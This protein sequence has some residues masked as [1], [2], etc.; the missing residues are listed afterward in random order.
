MF[1]EHGFLDDIVRYLRG[2]AFASPLIFRFFTEDIISN[3]VYYG[4]TVACCP[5]SPCATVLF[6]LV[7]GNALLKVHG[8][9]AA[10]NRTPT[11]KTRR[12]ALPKFC[13]QPLQ[14]AKSPLRPH[15]SCPAF[16]DALQLSAKVLEKSQFTSFVNPS[17]LKPPITVPLPHFPFPAPDC[18]LLL[19]SR[20]IIIDQKPR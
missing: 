9:K 8:I 19:L 2:P 17:H 18:P 1:Y 14:F 6:R 4:L 16:S 13:R 3:T 10:T 11:A 20:Y 5:V 12:P 15:L 7:V